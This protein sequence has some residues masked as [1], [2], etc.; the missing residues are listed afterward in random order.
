MQTLLNTLY[1]ST[2][3]SYLHLDNDTV[4]VEVERETRLRVPL[5]H[6]GGIVL[7][8]NVLVSPALI[9][10]LADD[11]KSLILLSEHGRFK[12]RMEGPTSGNILLRQAQHARAADPAFALAIARAFVAGKVKNTRQVLLRGGREAR[13]TE[14]SAR[15]T[16]RADDLAASLRALPAAGDLDTVRGLEGEAARQY[17]AG[18]NLVLRPESRAVFAMDGRSRRPPRDR[19]NALLSFLYAMLMN[20]CRSAVETVGLDPQLGFLHAVRPGRAALALDLM[21]EFRAL[22]D[23][24]ALTLI[25]RGQIQSGDFTEHDGGAVTLADGGRKTVIVAWQ[26][27][28]RE[29]LAHPLLQ[30]AVPIGL[31]PLLQARFLAR[32]LRGEMASY[33]PFTTR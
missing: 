33:L 18:L 29:E 32:T 15:L 14:D 1:V 28:K 13:D 3:M 23:R 2:P 31:L 11:G 5:H 16:R 26:E 8:G 25:N 21:E 9:H 27:K 6:L 4:R 22:A 20:D 12:A 10:R 19:I 24:L 17:F 30:Q 7:F